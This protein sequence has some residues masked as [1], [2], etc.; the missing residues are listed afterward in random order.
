MAD[1]TPTAVRALGSCWL[2]GVDV[3][4]PKDLLVAPT[5]DYMVHV[6]I[7]TPM[8]PQRPKIRMSVVGMMLLLLLLLN[9]TFLF[10][11]LLVVVEG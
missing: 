2:V 4:V 8:P 9:D 5:E 7:E 6:D 10:D 1:N 3:A 11:D